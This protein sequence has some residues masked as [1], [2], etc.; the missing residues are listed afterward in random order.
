[1]RAQPDRLLVALSLVVALPAG[2]IAERVHQ[3]AGRRFAFRFA[4]RA[5]R[6][7]GLTFDVHG[8]ELLD[9]IG[10][11]VLVPNPS[12]PLDNPALLGADERVRFLAVDGQ[13]PG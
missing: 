1:M 6:A 2:V 5:G 4:R 3:G 11:Y 7:C 10:T 13:I 8:G 9:P 12:S